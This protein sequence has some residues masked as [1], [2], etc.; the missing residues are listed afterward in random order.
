MD[1]LHVN[2]TGKFMNATEKLHTYITLTKEDRPMNDTPIIIIK[3]IGN[4]Y[5]MQPHSA[6]AQ[7]LMSQKSNNAFSYCC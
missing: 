7:T 5:I 6:F 1:I 3:K 2:N 4:V